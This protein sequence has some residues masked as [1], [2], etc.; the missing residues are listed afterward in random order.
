MKPKVSF[1]K[2]FFQLSQTEPEDGYLVGSRCS[3]C[4][5]VSFPKV[6]V[7]SQCFT[8]SE[9]EEIPLSKEGK[10]YTYSVIHVKHPRFGSPYVTGYVDLPEGVRVCARIVD[11]EPFDQKLKLGG[12]VRLVVTTIHE[13]ED[14]LMMG[15]AFR[16]V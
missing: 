6:P 16:P 14:A 3:R 10:L 4:G 5:H 15:Y 1:Q 2:A 12:D 9:V 13:G 7:C 11:C 8:D